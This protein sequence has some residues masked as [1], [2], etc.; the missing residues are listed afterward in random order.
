MTVGA[1]LK[2]NEPALIVPKR[3]GRNMGVELFRVVAMLMVL[4]LH[5]TG[6]GG[7]LKASEYLSTNYKIAL[8]LQ[9]MTYGS[10]NCYA[11]ISG[12]ANAKTEFK[13][14]RFV[15]LWLETAFLITAVN[16]V[17]HFL[18]PTVTVSKEGWLAGFFPLMCDGELWYFRAYF[19]LFALLPILNKGL[20]ALKKWQH[21]TMIVMLQMPTLF[22][23]IVGKDH[24]VFGGGYSALW[25]V[26]MYVI[27]AYF[28]IHGAPRWAK[29]Y[30]TLPAFFLFAGLAY[31]R[32]LIPEMQVAAGTLAHTSEW[33]TERN[34]L[35]SYLSPCMVVM[36]VML[37]L[38]FMR[39]KIRNPVS[40]RV[41][42]ALGKATWGVFV[43][44]VCQTF[45]S[46]TRFWEGFRVIASYP[47]WR[48]ILTFLGVGL[49]LYIVLSAVSILRGFLFDLLR[50]HK[51]IN[52]LS[53]RLV[54]WFER[55]KTP[56]IPSAEEKM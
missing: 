19:L 1:E 42:S 17:T 53:D 34:M 51:G 4:Y 52:W 37:L 9:V 35:L 10:V 8:F 13:F 40:C 54:G 6:Q 5:M 44:H 11:L 20:L 25:L 50:I 43:I 46:D 31:I 38:F 33:Y 32:K 7:V 27:G 55:K 22:R 14:R 45:W 56:D 21:I 3:E 28:R 2:N 15:Y 41:I 18:V 16:L 26:C 48:M 36:S 12:F 49:G 23:L 47:A 39:L 30:V 29:P 24:F